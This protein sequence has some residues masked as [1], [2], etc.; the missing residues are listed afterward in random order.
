VILKPQDVVVTL[1]LLSYGSDRPSYGQ[2]GLDLGM[3]ASEVHASVKRAQ[4]ARLLH[5]PELE[6]KPNPTALAEFLVHG[7][8]YV[9]PADRGEPTR[10]ILTSYAA[11]PLCRMIT[12]P[13]DLPPVWPHPAGTKRGVTLTPLYKTVPLAATKDEKLYQLLALVDAIRDGRARERKLAEQEIVN[14]LR[15]CDAQAES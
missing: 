9:F 2:M 10:G 15:G 6:N 3:S 11:E 12:Q 13:D 4:K 5:G 14:R 8:K 1:K 7:L